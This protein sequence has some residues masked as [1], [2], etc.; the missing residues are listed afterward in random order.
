VDDHDFRARLCWSAQ[1]PRAAP[2]CR[3]PVDGIRDGR[4]KYAKLGSGGCRAS[5]QQDCRHHYIHYR[6]HGDHVRRSRRAF[7]ER[8]STHRPA[9]RR[10]CGC[11][12]RDLDDRTCFDTVTVASFGGFRY[13]LEF[14]ARYDVD[15]RRTSNSAPAAGEYRDG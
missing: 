8:R 4:G 1:N 13:A 7:A 10:R 5:A 14:D 9:V 15:R 3:Y 12:R 6:R 2:D 11:A